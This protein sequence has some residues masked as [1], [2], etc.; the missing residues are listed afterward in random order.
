MNIQFSA[1]PITDVQAYLAESA[2]RR[3][4]LMRPAA[5]APVAPVEVPKP[6][7]VPA[8]PRLYRAHDAHIVAWQ[9]W[10]ASAGSPLKNYIVTRCEELGIPYETIISQRKTNDVAF[11]RQM[12]MWEIKNIVKPETSYPAIGRMFG[13]RDH[14]TVIHAIRAH[15]RRIANEPEAK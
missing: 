8:R 5:R 1:K 13:G 2:A 11:A 10:R 6:V 15:A 3:N 9:K 7:E 14:T 4:R 12:I